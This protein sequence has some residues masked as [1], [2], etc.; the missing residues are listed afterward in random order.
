[1]ALTTYRSKVAVTAQ[2]KRAAYA[3]IQYL[4]DH[5]LSFGVDLLRIERMADG[6]IEIDFTNPIPVGQVDHLN[7][8]GPV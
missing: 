8:Q 1:M 3:S 5:I 6:F 4:L 7:L 2:N